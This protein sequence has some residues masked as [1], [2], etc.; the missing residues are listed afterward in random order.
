MIYQE[1][2]HV[3]H[4]FTSQVAS[5][6]TFVFNRLLNPYC[7]RPVPFITNTLFDLPGCNNIVDLYSLANENRLFQRLDAGLQNRLHWS[8]FFYQALTKIHPQIIHAH[9]SGAAEACCWSARKLSIP[10]IANFYGLETKYHV[11]DPSWLPRYQRLY[12]E[13][14]SFICSSEDM[15][16][17]MI[18]SGCPEEKIHVVRCGVDVDLFCGKPKAWCSDEPLCLLSIARLHKEKGLNYLVDACH[19]LNNAG[20]KNWSLDIIG[21]GDEESFLQ[22]QILEYEL[23]KQV[24]L[25]GVLPPAS[26]AEA[27]RNAHIMIL[28]S[29]KETQGV[30]LQEAQGTGTPVITTSVGGIPEGVIDQETG[31]IVEPENPK[32]IFEAIF[33]FIENPDLLIKM[34]QRGR[35]LVQSKFTRSIEYDKLASVYELFT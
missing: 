14:N 6:E 4:I 11:H 23:E 24:N 10:L 18:V 20:F 27:L 9:F 5:I 31:Y 1:Q 33:S 29:L 26:V 22:E 15:R 25:V 12:R 34:G 28:P 2:Y 19:M 17:E 21:K 30:V 32:A 16:R 3:A 35:Q 7:M 13:V 8:L